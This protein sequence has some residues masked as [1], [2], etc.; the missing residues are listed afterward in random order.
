[1]RFLKIRFLICCW[2]SFVGLLVDSDGVE[3]KK[4]KAEPNAQ[5]TPRPKQMRL[6]RRVLRFLCAVTLLLSSALAALSLHLHLLLR[7]DA[8]IAL[9]VLGMYVS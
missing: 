7:L 6:S 5:K 4:R 3:A 9:T 8:S 2:C 1:M